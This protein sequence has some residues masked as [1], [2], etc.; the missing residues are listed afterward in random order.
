MLAS[1]TFSKVIDDAPD[2]TSV[3]VGNAGD[4]AKVAQDTLNPNNERG[5]GVNDIRHRFVFSSV[6]DLNYA[7]SV[8][9]AAAKA[10]LSGW[11]LSTISQL[12]SGQ[13]VSAVVTGD[14]NNDGNNFNDRVPGVGRN[15]IT[16]PELMD[17]DL[18][19][20]RDIPIHERA[21]LRLIFEGFDIT[22]RANF[23]GIQNTQYTF[24]GGVF[25]P[26]TNF[27]TKLTMQPQ[28]VGSRVLQLAAKF[29]F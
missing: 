21:R 7:K 18:R 15:T 5:L 11:T 1:Y 3:V 19:L 25:T 4:D 2:A 13:P 20:T 10:L 26:T 22:N 23:S 9:N 12:Q 16:G 8:N 27:L 24:K 6:W 28:G 29:T 17:W 14:P